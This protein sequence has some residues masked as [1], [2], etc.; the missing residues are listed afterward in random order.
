VIFLLSIP[1]ALVWLSIAFWLL[2]TPVGILL[3]R[4]RPP[5]FGGPAAH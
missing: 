3:N 1:L 5:Q 4:H 2:N